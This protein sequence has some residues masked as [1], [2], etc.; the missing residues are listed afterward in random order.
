LRLQQRSGGFTLI[1]LLVVIAIIA[2]LSAILFPVFAQAREKAR[3]TSCLSNTK[4][5]GLAG[6]MYAQDFDETLPPWRVN[7]RLYWVGGRAISS[8][9]LDKTLG[10]LWPYVKSGDLQKCPSYVG[11]QNLGGTGYGIN[12]SL[13]QL[14]LSEL[15]RPTETLFFA[16]AGI[17]NFP[18]VGQVGETI[19]IQP[20]IRWVPSPEMD[21]RHQGMANLVWGDGHAKSL[22]K[23]AFLTLLPQNQQRPDRKFVGDVLMA[24]QKDN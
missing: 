11:G 16:D 24:P 13:S 6:L 4:Q 5:I 20:P 18:V 10:L 15:D 19:V 22:K 12:L 17:P 1:E 7:N 21:F 23:E 9:P 2:I 3:T 14:A 8:G